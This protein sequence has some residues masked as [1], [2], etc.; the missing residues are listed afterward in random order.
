MLEAMWYIGPGEQS[1]VFWLGRVPKLNVGALN[2][3]GSWLDVPLSNKTENT[4][5][6]EII[7]IRPAYEK[8]FFIIPV[9]PGR[10]Y[11]G[12]GLV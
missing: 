6:I 3:V 12:P 1:E 5:S 4:L 10:A 9:S 2:L 8:I 7:K 11:F